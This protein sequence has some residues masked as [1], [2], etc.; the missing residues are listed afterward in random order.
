MSS[1]HCLFCEGVTPEVFVKDNILNF[2][3]N[4]P[5]NPNS[6]A[7]RKSPTKDFIKTQNSL[8]G[9]YL[10]NEDLPISNHCSEE[11]EK[12]FYN[13]DSHSSDDES[14]SV[15]IGFK[16]R[17]RNKTR[18]KREK[19]ETVSQRRIRSLSE[20]I[21]DIEARNK[22]AKKEMDK[23]MTKIKSDSGSTSGV[24]TLFVLFSGNHDSWECV[25]GL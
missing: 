18:P 25:H 22:A 16:R 4:L 23:K 13:T 7:Q 9:N 1:G 15:D 10:L 17:R 24:R 11:V 5:V 3:W 21:G 6:A 20:A 19:R 8:P 2:A 12:A 14:D